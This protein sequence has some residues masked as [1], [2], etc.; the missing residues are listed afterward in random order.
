MRINNSLRGSNRTN[1]PTNLPITEINE[2]TLIAEDGSDIL[3]E[4]GTTMI[5]DIFNLLCEDGN[6]LL[7]E[8]NRTFISE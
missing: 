8:D 1:Q 7:S 2:Y 4:D 5:F 6:I 3:C